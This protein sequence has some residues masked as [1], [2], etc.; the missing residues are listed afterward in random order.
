MAVTA[1][2]VKELRELTGAGMVDCKN[3]L[4]ETDSDIQKA[5]NYLRE[6]GLAAAAKKAGRIAAEGVVEILISD[7][8]KKG[9]V[10]EVNSETDFVAKN[11]EFRTFVDQVAKQA[12]A[13]CTA[14]IEAFMDEKWAADPSVSVKEALSQK[15]AI[16]GENLNIRRF[17]KIETTDKGVLS[18]YIHGGGKMGVLLELEAPAGNELVAESG[19]NI[20]MQI[21]A[22]YPKYVSRDEIDP[23]FIAKE[24]EILTAQAANDEKNANKP[25]QVIEKMIEGRL[26]KSL[27]DYCLVEQAYVKDNDVTVGQYLESVGKQV[28]SPVVAKRFIC[29]ERG[30]GIEKKEENFADEVNKVING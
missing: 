24:K 4:I 12:L 29:F 10:V 26:N 27:K 20:C 30:E 21:A 13:T 9:V 8:G 3:A 16:I 6:K 7:D 28:G 15:I 1:A 25:A 23:E 17:S 5:I 14:D 2:M 11:A 18:Y 19:K 22:M